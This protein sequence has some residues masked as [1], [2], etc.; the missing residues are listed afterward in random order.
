MDPYPIWVIAIGFAVITLACYE[1]GF[2][3][4]RWWQERMPGE[5]E[6]PTG[7]LV[8]SI[9]ALM[10]FLLAVTMGMASD[11][12]DTRRQLVVQEANAISKTYLEADY[13]PQPAADQIK[14]LLREYLPLRIA[15]TTD[16]AVVQA[17]FQKSQELHAQ[18]WAIFEGY[19]RSGN[20]TDLMS[21]LGEALTEI[22]TLDETRT[23]ARDYARVPETVLLLLL[24]GSALS[25][26][27][28]GYG[29]GLTGRRSVLSALVL[30]VVLGAVLTLVIDLDRP[31]EGFLTVSQQALLDVQ[32]WIGA[33]SH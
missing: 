11:R 16:R 22:R 5:Q 2:R 7:V 15:N 17:N 25:L 23:V 1:G 14:E 27:M 3:L 29:A 33:P 9:L 21:S 6:G 12:F 13:L 31:Q 10:A 20:L 18:M 4:G 19:A 32:Q 24:A 26:G 28:V 30:V 8:S